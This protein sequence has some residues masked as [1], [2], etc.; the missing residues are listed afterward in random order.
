[1]GVNKNNTRLGVRANGAL[2]A[3]DCQRLRSGGLGQAREVER[4]REVRRL[5]HQLDGVPHPLTRLA[6]VPT[7]LALFALAGL[8][9]ARERGDGAEFDP[10]SVVGRHGRVLLLDHHQ[11][12]VAVL[13]GVQQVGALLVALGRHELLRLA[14]KPPDS[15]RPVCLTYFVDH[16]SSF[17]SGSDWPVVSLLL[18]HIIN[19]NT[20]AVRR[21]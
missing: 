5:R 3:G 7:E 11:A 18:Y 9:A 19:I 21:A 10:S 17:H 16:D 2:A 4:D 12:G 8:G 15:G 20:M 14:A 1:M 6:V 13:A